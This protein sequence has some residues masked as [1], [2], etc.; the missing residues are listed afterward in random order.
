VRRRRVDRQVG[1]AVLVVGG[2]PAQRASQH[3]VEGPLLAVRVVERR[4]I[5]RTLRFEAAR[6]GQQHRGRPG[7]GGRRQVIRVV[8]LQLVAVELGGGHVQQQGPPAERSGQAVERLVHLGGP[9]DV[10]GEGADGLAAA[11]GTDRHRDDPPP[12]PGGL[13]GGPA[14]GDD[15]GDL[16][17]DGRQDLADEAGIQDAVEHHQQGLARQRLGQGPPSGGD[18]RP[19]LIGHLQDRGS[20]AG[21]QLQDAPGEGAPDP[22]V[23]GRLPGQDGLAIPPVSPQGGRPSPGPDSISEPTARSSSSGRSTI[24]EGGRGT[25]N[26]RG[27]P[28]EVATPSRATAV[29]TGTA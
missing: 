29:R 10:S 19:K 12:D 7:F 4:R 15:D 24:P 18:A 27:G 9:G 3:P 14:G 28:V 25:S 8:R 1:E 11:Q 2:Q 23:M 22:L 20:L 17:G 6:V 26:R 13:Q 21:G 16:L 5:G